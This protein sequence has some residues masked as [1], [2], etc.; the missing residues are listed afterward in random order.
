MMESVV[1]HGTGT[2]A[3]I[4]GVTGGRQ[5]GHRGEC[6][7]GSAARLVRCVR[8]GSPT[9]DRRRGPRR[10]RRRCQ[11]RDRRR[12]RGADR[13][14]RH[15]GRTEEAAMTASTDSKRPTKEV[16]TMTEPRRLGGRYELGEVLGYG[17]MAE[18]HRGRDIRLGR[19]VA[20]KILARRP[21]PRPLVPG[22]LPPRGAVG[23][24]AESP[25]DRGRLRHR[26]EHARRRARCPTSSWSTSRAERC[27]I[28]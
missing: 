14:G 19:D 23:R 21:R 28:C 12:G 16:S 13:E 15:S 17:G 5:D 20:V 2:S 26:R 22:P 11:R 1:Q 7:R 18:V 9:D 25:V 8:A 24:V 3:Q 27:A 4:T 10:E 6:G